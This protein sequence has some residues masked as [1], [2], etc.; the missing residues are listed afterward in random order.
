M[1]IDCHTHIWSSRT[2]LGQAENFSCLTHAPLDGANPA[3]HSLAAQPAD[4]SFV[5]GFTSDLLGCDIPNESLAAYARTN[6]SRII[7]WAGV[8]PTRKNCLDQVK[9]L[10]AQNAFAGLTVSPACQSFHPADSRAMMLYELA[11]ELRLP[12]YFLQGRTLPHRA[13][14]PFADPTALDEIARTFPHLTIAISH[15]GIPWLEQTLAL[16]A[17][18]A[19]VFSDTAGL[20]G[21]PQHAYRALA[22]AC[23]MNVTDK[24]LLASDFPRHTVRQAVEA[25]YNAN[26][27]SADCIMPPL[28]RDQL[29][30][31][32]ERDSLTALGLQRFKAKTIQILAAD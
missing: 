19:N 30:T 9:S 21:N 25:V 8:D 22:L 1:I 26:K 28:P 6:P 32:V 13:V 7:P 3:D 27:L 29:R 14:L 20:T 17:K 15:L 12:L 10:A 31:I 5:L 2:G 24:I 23:E 18:H 16:L 11:D 4:A